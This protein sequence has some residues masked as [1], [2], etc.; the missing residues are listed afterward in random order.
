MNEDETLREI[1]TLIALMGEGL[2]AALGAI[3]WASPVVSFGNPAR[4]KIA[5][6]GLNPSNLEFI[7]KTGRQ[8]LEP[9]NRF[10]SLSSLGAKNWKEI[11]AIGVWRIWQSCEDYFYRNPYN[12]WFRRLDRVLIETGASYY[13][14]I[15]EQA[16]HLDL[17]P[18][19]TIQK[20]SSL[21]HEQQSKLIEIGIP[22]LARTLSRSAISVLIL[23]G[24]SVT[25]EFSQIVA[26]NSFTSTIEPTWALQNGRVQ[27]VAY[28]G[29]VHEVGGIPLQRELLILGFNHNIQSSFGVTS[30]VVSQIA[31]WIGRLSE[32]A[33]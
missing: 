23:N 19:A 5:T 6:L 13:S 3:P 2:P 7:D 22:S 25:R 27:G 24:S 15:G 30:H 12:Q 28:V 1:E 4:C 26:P 18:F 20:W 9:E 17:V 33:L 32:E 21:N 14:R 16:C 11:S 10:E 29:R 31:S 8:L